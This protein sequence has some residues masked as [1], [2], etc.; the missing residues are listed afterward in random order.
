MKKNNIDL[1]DLYIERKWLIVDVN[2]D[3]YLLCHSTIK[4]LLTR[5]N[6]L[7][8]PKEKEIEISKTWMVKNRIYKCDLFVYDTNF[9]WGLIERDVIIN[10]NEHFQS[11]EALM[12]YL[13]LQEPTITIVPMSKK[14]KDEFLENVRLNS[15]KW[16]EILFGVKTG[17][18]VTSIGFDTKKWTNFTFNNWILD[19]E[20]G[21]FEEWNYELTQNTSINLTYP[22]DQIKDLVLWNSLADCLS[23]EKYIS[24]EKD[25]SAITLGYMVAWIFRQEYKKIHNEFP[26]LGIEWYT[27]YGK[28]SLLN[29]ASWVSGYNR[30][31]V[32][33]VCDTDYAFEV[34]MNCMW[35]WFYYFD[36]IQKAS[37]KLL[38]YIQA[39]YNSWEN[40]KWW[41][42]G[43][44]SKLQ[45]FRKDCSLFCTWE[46]LPQHEEALLNRFVV[47][48]PTEAFTIKQNVK[49]EEELM[50]YKELTWETMNTDYLT[51]EQIK[52]L[53]I[54][55]YRP[56]FLNILR[57]K[58]KIDFKYYHDKALKLIDE[59]LNKWVLDVR[60]KN[61]LVA[62]ITWYLILKWDTVNESEVYD[63][64]IMYFNKLDKYIKNAIISWSIVQYICQHT[65]EL[66]SWTWKVKGYTSNNPMIYLKNT[67]REQWIVL[68]VQTL[69]KYMADKFASPLKVKHIEQQFRQLL[70][71]QNYSTKVVKVAK[72]ELNFTWTFISL[73]KVKQNESLRV[74][75]DYVLLY[76]NEHMRELTHVKDWEKADTEIYPK[77]Q[78]KVM[79]NGTL[80]KLI[81]EMNDTCKSSQYFDTD[82]FQKIEEEE[83]L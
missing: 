52:T 59:T 14:E 50:K 23:I 49:D 30:S 83:V 32:S 31:S 25:I 13:K 79:P 53:A 37:D 36:E 72:G 4:E 17:Y 42:D 38:K 35:W 69:V 75:R 46:L 24:K 39:A 26:F 64:I 57:N 62:P 22:N 21:K 68:Q 20:T 27:W 19:T 6:F 66:C 47:L 43:D 58:S 55:Y 40:H 18:K 71:I 77:I 67:E 7:L 41:A 12:S 16:F 61:N 80:E 51:T 9:W 2:S 70:G 29:F 1:L 82:T 44:W 45:V 15:L 11:F 81:N 33:W 28:T 54:Q 8:F 74:I 63:I 34:G 76:L 5:C 3:N 73:E 78:A 60:Y 10:Q 48:S 65:W 56:R